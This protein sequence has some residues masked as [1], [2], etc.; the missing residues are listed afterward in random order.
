MSVVPVTPEDIT[1]AQKI[2]IDGAGHSDFVHP[3]LSRNSLGWQMFCQIK[4]L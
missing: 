1:G 2:F 4:S 3:G